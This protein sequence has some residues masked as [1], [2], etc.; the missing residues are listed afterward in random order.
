MNVTKDTI[1]S[2]NSGPKSNGE[3]EN[4]KKMNIIAANNKEDYISSQKKNI[5]YMAFKNIKDRYQYK[6]QR[7]DKIKSRGKE[8]LNEF[9]LPL[10]NSNVKN[11]KRKDTFQKMKSDNLKDKLFM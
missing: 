4:I 1:D 2:P 10:I 11:I 6:E 5:F 7:M 3:M 9:K 8:I